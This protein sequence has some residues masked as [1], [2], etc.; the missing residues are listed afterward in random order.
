MRAEERAAARAEVEKVLVE[1]QDWQ[2]KQLAGMRRRETE[3]SENLRKREA[4]FEA[5]CYEHR[6]RM[7][8][9]IEGLRAR[10]AQLQTEGILQLC[11]AS[12]EAGGGFDSFYTSVFEDT[13]RPGEGKGLTQLVEEVRRKDER[14][15][16][17][18]R[19]LL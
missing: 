4:A 17:R 8:N 9:E 13:I 6:Q 2:A 19:R 5:S 11:D 7:L 15:E 18:L 1:Q 14:A 10:E 12:I 16:E 3:A